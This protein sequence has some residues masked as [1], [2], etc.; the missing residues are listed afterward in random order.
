V[1][2][3]GCNHNGDPVLA[4]KMVEV[5]VLSILLPTTGAN[6]ALRPSF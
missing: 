2:E 5:S 1:A 4:K 6:Q 3:I